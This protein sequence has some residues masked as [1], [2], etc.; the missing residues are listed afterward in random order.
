MPETN[1]V[2]SNTVTGPWVA[3]VN[4]TERTHPA[5]LVLIRLSG[6]AGEMPKIKQI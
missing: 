5:R 6:R 1:C 3:G 2:V 4:F